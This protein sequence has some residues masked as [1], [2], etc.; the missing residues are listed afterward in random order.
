MWAYDENDEET[1]L[2]EERDAKYLRDNPALESGLWAEWVG[3]VC[4][5]EKMPPPNTE[6]WAV[7]KSKFYSGKAPVDSVA[8]LKK[9]RGVL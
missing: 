9:L 3:V 6:E 5:W 8:E 2:P 7:L 1:W 4:G